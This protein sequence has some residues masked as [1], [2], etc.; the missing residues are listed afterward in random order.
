V[1]LSSFV[2]S[3]LQDWK[4]PKRTFY[5]NFCCQT[6][7][8]SRNPGYEK[9]QFS[10]ITFVLHHY[11]GEVEYD[12]IGWLEINKDL[13]LALKKSVNTFIAMTT[14]IMMTTI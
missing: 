1:Q 7:R 10:K 9:V 8:A 13:E 5:L 2:S 14:M 4:S 11:A 3:I 6:L 12:A